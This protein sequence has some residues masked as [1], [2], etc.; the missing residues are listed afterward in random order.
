MS[1]SDVSEGIWCGQNICSNTK[2]F[3]NYNK[4]GKK[5]QKLSNEVQKKNKAEQ[6]KEK[7]VLSCRKHRMCA[8][9]IRKVNIHKKQTKLQNARIHSILF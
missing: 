3:K 8:Q 2:K 7:S 5:L 1:G 4:K 9:K 6:K